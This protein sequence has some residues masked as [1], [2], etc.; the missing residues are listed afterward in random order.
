MTA[1]SSCGCGYFS[2]ALDYKEA[3]DA[4]KEDAGTRTVLFDHDDLQR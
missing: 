1:Q 4:T 3:H 2:K